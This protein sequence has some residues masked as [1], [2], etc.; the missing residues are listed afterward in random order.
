MKIW[1]SVLLKI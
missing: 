1:G